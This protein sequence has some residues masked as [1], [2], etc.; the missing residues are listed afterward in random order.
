[1]RGQIFFEFTGTWFLSSSNMGFF[2]EFKILA[3]W[4]RAQKKH[5][6]KFIEFSTR[7]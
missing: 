4:S 3:A 2:D 5:I 1:M 6:T 7:V